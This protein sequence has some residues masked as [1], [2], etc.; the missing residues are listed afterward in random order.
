MTRT[1]QSFTFS[2]AFSI[3]DFGAVMLYGYGF[4]RTGMSGGGMFDGY[5]RLIGMVTG[6]T[7]QNEVAG[8]PHITYL[9]SDRRAPI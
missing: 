1:T 6:G 4:A 5:G 2:K 8:V 7:Q 9:P 3:A